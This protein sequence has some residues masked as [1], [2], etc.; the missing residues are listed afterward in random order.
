MV[1]LAESGGNS[2]QSPDTEAVVPRRYEIRTI[3][4]DLPWSWLQKGFND[5]RRSGYLGCVHGAWYALLGFA[6]TAFLWF[7][8][9]L[10]IGLPLAA[11]FTLIGPIAAVGLY[12]ISQ[13]L[14]AGRPASLSDSVLAWRVNF[15]QIALMGLALTMLAL[16]WMRTA[17][18]IFFLFFGIGADIPAPTAAS[19]VETFLSA[20][21]L[22]FLITGVIAGGFFAIVAFT[23][24]AVSIPYLLD[25]TDS[26]VIEAIIV[27]CQAVLRNFWPMMLW[28]WLIALFIG[29][30]ILT[31]FVGL[32]IVLPIIGH[33]TWHA[34]SDLVAHP[35]RRAA[36]ALPGP[37]TSAPAPE[38][39]AAPEAT[40][41][42]S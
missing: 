36:A 5:L 9:V 13:D 1:D 20:S 3:D 2:A 38:A 4:K 24:C 11:L 41:S 28:A 6:L 23:V 12:R 16:F 35:D 27:S 39:I 37:D 33:A 40:P 15:M 32:I 29:F 25:R 31:G 34:Y 10:F 26:N 42:E 30:G 21:S 14:A 7:Q 18:L 19:F 8:G 22:P 17:F